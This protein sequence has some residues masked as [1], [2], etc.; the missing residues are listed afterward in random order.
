MN[1]HRRRHRIRIFR[2]DLLVALL[3]VGAG[4]GACVRWPEKV[5]AAIAIPMAVLVALLAWRSSR[6]R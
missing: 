6:F 2:T 4:I 5:V 1:G 3:L